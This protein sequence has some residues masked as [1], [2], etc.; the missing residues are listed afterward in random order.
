MRKLASLIGNS[1]FI[2]MI[3]IM[4]VMVFFLVKGKLDK[5]G[6]PKIAGYQIYV[7]LSGSMNPT[8]DTGSVIAIKPVNPEEV[9]EGNIITFQEPGE[10]KRI[11]THRVLEVRK[12]KSGS[13]FI[14]KGDAN[15]VA[16]IK[17][18]PGENIIGK[19]SLWIPYAG[20]LMEFVK[21][22]KGLLLLLVLPG[23]LLVVTELFQIYK[24][25]MKAEE[26]EKKKKLENEQ[27]EIANAEG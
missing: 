23:A 16:D 3:V 25:M 17:P 4:V 8:F 18:V 24:T 7:V 10:Q 6:V 2:L 11:V 20:Y 22:K 19:V 21:T 12:D 27:T 26:E 15:N 1:L 5:D 9:V 13:S 14:T